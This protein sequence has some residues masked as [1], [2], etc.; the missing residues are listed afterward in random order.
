MITI[1]G[2]LVLAIFVAC[3]RA[4][5]GLFDDALVAPGY[6]HVKGAR[7][8]G[9]ELG[10]VAF[11]FGADGDANVCGRLCTSW[12]ASS[13]EACRLFAFEPFHRETD[14]ISGKRMYQPICKFYD[15]CTPRDST[16]RVHLYVT[17][18]DPQGPDRVTF[19]A[20]GYTHQPQYQ[21]EERSLGVYNLPDKTN[22]TADACAKACAKTD[23]GSDGEPCSAFVFQP[24]Y[25]RTDRITGLRTYTP[26]CKLYSECTLKD[27]ADGTVH[28]YISEEREKTQLEP[29][30]EDRTYFRG[31]TSSWGSMCQERAMWERVDCV[32]HCAAR[33]YQVMGL[34]TQ[35]CSAF[36]Y[37]AETRMCKVYR[38]ECTKKQGKGNWLYRVCD[39][40]EA[41]RTGQCVP[42]DWN[43]SLEDI[44]DTGKWAMDY[45]KQTMTFELN[46][47]PSRNRQVPAGMALM[48]QRNIA[49][50]K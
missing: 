22:V 41:D 39:G 18:N 28:A 34:G 38:G 31:Y 44:G 40:P 26:R 23:S 46:R 27:G 21:C 9:K 43:E 20:E 10:R 2:S 11:N 7:C 3:V 16:S 25:A 12:E 4:D 29:A 37:N 19:L 5:V 35:R 36:V 30:G 49:F 24:F 13:G 17:E 50:K 42:S 45:R 1:S 32:Q 8:R 15:E 33:C 14:P 47:C 48:E 6:T